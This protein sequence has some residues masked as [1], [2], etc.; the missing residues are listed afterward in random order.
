MQNILYFGDWQS[1]AWKNKNFVPIIQSPIC[2]RGSNSV[3]SIVVQSD[4]LITQ[5]N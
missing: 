4:G 3:S 2:D 1:L 5:K